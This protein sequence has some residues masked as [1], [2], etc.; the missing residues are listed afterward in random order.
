MLLF[1]LIFVIILRSIRT[2]V[3]QNGSK[4]NRFIRSI[5]RKPQIFPSFQNFVRYRL[6]AY[7]IMVPLKKENTEWDGCYGHDMK[8][9][10]SNQQYLIQQKPWTYVWLYSTS[11]R[12]VAE[13]VP[14]LEHTTCVLSAWSRLSN[15]QPVLDVIIHSTLFTHLSRG[16]S[17]RSSNCRPTIVPPDRAS[18]PLW[19]KTPRTPCTKD[20]YPCQNDNLSKSF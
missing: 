8:G 15:Q 6:N 9:D 3:A 20:P 11:R 14:K 2:P 10:I 13:R 17:T 12:W 4:R 7:S 18:K 16:V 19:L 1:L 5:Q